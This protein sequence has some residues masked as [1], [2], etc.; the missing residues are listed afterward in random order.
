M[1]IKIVKDLDKFK[2]MY[3]TSKYQLWL[4]YSSDRYNTIKE[5]QKALKKI[6]F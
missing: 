3:Y 6:E 1:K 5:A 4:T 2:I